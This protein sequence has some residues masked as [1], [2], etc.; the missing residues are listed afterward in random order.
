MNLRN[1]LLSR[2]SFKQLR[3]TNNSSMTFFLLRSFLLGKQEL[4]WKPS[5]GLIHDASS[6]ADVETL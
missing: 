4:L 2:S 3:L 5:N 1:G 6:N